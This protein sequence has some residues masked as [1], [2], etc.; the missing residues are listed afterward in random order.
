MH[1]SLDENPE[2]V[3]KNPVE[4]PKNDCKP[5]FEPPQGQ[6][7]TTTTT[8]EQSLVQKKQKLKDAVK[9]LVKGLADKNKKKSKK[10]KKTEKTKKIE[11][12]ENQKK[13]EKTEKSVK[14]EKAEKSVKSK[15][16]EVKSQPQPE[17]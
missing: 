11:K 9:V 2:A 17:K 8:D 12:V 7:S 6:G 14:S 1:S 13:S 16:A 10:Q 3:N 15:L 4:E 5:K